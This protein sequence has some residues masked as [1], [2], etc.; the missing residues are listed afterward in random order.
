MPLFLLLIAVIILEVVTGYCFGFDCDVMYPFKIPWLLFT[1]GL[2]VLILMCRAGYCPLRRGNVTMRALLCVPDVQT[3]TEE[4]VVG[5]APQC[6]TSGCSPLALPGGILAFGQNILEV[7]MDLFFFFNF[8]LAINN[9]FFSCCGTNHVNGS[10]KI[11]TEMMK[12]YKSLSFTTS[13]LRFCFH[14]NLHICWHCDSCFY[15]VICGSVA[16]QL[17]VLLLPVLNYGCIHCRWIHH[18][19]GSSCCKYWAKSLAWL[20]WCQSGMFCRADVHGICF[21]VF[22]GNY[23]KD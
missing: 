14:I 19:D 1:S 4:L 18:L 17:D 16:N 13:G 2:W 7:H 3:V 8:F 9:Y 20:C 5:L 11:I 21:V 12:K 22:N 6:S 23:R 15:F 10:S